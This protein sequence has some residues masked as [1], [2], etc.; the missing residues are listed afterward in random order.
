MD[1]ISRELEIQKMIE[2][3]DRINGAKFIN[4]SEIKFHP[5]RDKSTL[6][7][8]GYISADEYAKKR[9]Q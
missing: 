7:E 9:L 1:F 3:Q 4:E 2:E 5:Y 6:K 8:Q